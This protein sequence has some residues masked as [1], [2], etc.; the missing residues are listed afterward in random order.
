MEKPK[1]SFWQIWN[2]SFG[3]LGVQIGYSLQN[4]NTSRILEAL[5]ADVHSIGYFWLAAPLAGLIVQPIIGLSSDKTWTR[6]GRRIP[7]IFGG[8]IVSALAMFFM[9]NAEYFTYLLPPL[10]FGATMLLL[11]DT[12][13][14]VTMQPFRALV[15]DMVNDEQRNLGYSLQSALINFGAVFGSL[16]PWIL[17]KSGI[18]NVPAEGEKVASSVIWSFYIGGAILL[19]SVLWTVFRTKEYAPKEHALYNKIDLEANEKKEKTS[20]FSLIG[21]APKIFWQLGFVQFFSWFSLFLMWVYTTRAIAN[22][23]WGP[24]AIDAKSIG[25]NEAGDW[26]GVMFA[27]Y[28]AVAALYSLLI[29]KIAKAIGRKKVYSFS[30]LLGGLG[31]ISMMFVHD[32]SILLLSISGVGLAW[33]AILAMPYAMLSGSL[34][35]D[36]MGVYMGLFNATITL[37]QITAGILGSTLIAFFGGNPMTI[38]VIAGVSMLIAG[39]AVFLVKQNSAT[40]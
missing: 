29:P 6:L 21:N 35:A 31:L 30:L 40:E 37:P 39:L 28:S 23:V 2:L 3:F 27:F 20:I 22:Q 33:A 32:K 10:V 25:F 24:D 36:K 15:G 5:G 17:A 9:P 38:I 1:L 18:A 26:T 14:N 11:M 16:L 7:F 4:G 13:F 12:S 34:P 19:V 8:A